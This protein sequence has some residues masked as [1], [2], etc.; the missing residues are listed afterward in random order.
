M[1]MAVS[2]I[3][4]FQRLAEHGGYDIHGLVDKSV[5]VGSHIAGAEQTFRGSCGGRQHGVHIDSGF[6][7]LL[8]SQQSGVCIVSIY[9]DDG[10][11]AHADL[12]ASVE[13]A[14]AGAGGDG[15]EPF[16]QL[17]MAAQYPQRGQSR[18]A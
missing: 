2:A 1:T 10:S 14:L 4:F 6:V 17:G 9:R 8:G 18:G 15:V 3:V 7:Y 13:Q 16:R 11:V 12:E 5:G